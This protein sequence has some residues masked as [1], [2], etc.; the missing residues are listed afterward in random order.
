MDIIEAVK[1]NIT[2]MKAEM[3]A[4]QQQALEMQESD[5]IEA[6]KRNVTAMKA[7]MEAAQ[8]QALETQENDTNKEDEA[9]EEEAASQTTQQ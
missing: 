3:E 8:Q 6:V 5:A 9:S 7:E 1:R 4:A 2:A